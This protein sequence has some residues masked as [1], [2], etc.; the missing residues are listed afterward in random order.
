MNV[1][2]YLRLVLWA[3]RRYTRD[4]VLTITARGE[5]SIYML[6][7]RAAWN[8]YMGAPLPRLQLPPAPWRVAANAGLPHGG[9]MTRRPLIDVFLDAAAAVALG[10][11]G[12]IVLIAELSK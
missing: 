5:P 6:I 11:V 3:R 2:L 8:R 9:R 12:A 7:E 10:L 4:G 1:T